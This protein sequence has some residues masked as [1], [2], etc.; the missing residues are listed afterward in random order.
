MEV[1]FKDT[2][3][4]WLLNPATGKFAFVFVA[5]VVIAIS[6]RLLRRNVSRMLRDNTAQYQARKGI[7]FVGLLPPSSWSSWF[8][9]I[10]SV[11]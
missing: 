8:S 9:A 7:A 3:E 2:L 6:T 4:S 11:D 5:L 10:G 1:Q